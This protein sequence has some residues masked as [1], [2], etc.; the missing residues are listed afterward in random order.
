MIRF[1]MK[2]PPTLPG[3]RKQASRL[4]VATSL[5]KF[6][7]FSPWAWISDDQAGYLRDRT[8]AEAVAFEGGRLEVLSMVN[9]LDTV[10]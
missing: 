5:A 8:G 6:M 7:A 3:W 2:A 4:R 1:R 10:E 9:A